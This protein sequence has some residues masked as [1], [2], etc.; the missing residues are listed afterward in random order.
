LIFAA[1]DHSQ[2]TNF[3]D[4]LTMQ[5]LASRSCELLRSF[6]VHVAKPLNQAGLSE[7]DLAHVSSLVSEFLQ[8]AIERENFY[9]LFDRARPTYPLYGQVAQVTLPTHELAYSYITSCIEAGRPALITNILNKLLVTKQGDAKMLNAHVFMPLISAIELKLHNVPTQ[10][11]D[12]WRRLCEDTVKTFIQ[13][14][15]TLKTFPVD[16]ETKS[17]VFA[18]ASSGESALLSHT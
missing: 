12:A 14:R 16:T 3:H 4:S 9:T 8:T 2:L 6:A 10:V 11:A 1:K 13:S 17:V 5:L 7:E 18:V 15:Q